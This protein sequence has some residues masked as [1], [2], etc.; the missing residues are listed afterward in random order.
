MTPSI[1]ARLDTPPNVFVKGLIGGGAITSG[2]QNDE[3]WGV[4]AGPTSFEVKL[5][6][7]YDPAQSDFPPA[8]NAA[9]DIGRRSTFSIGAEKSSSSMFAQ[10]AYRFY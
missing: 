5:A 7:G 1:F 9:P 8:E 6:I 2:K 4:L 3:D 10:L